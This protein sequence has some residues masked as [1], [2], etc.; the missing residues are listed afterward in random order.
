M[1]YL[2][3]FHSQE[4]TEA[5]PL[6]TQT[7]KELKNHG[8]NWHVWTYLDGEILENPSPEELEDVKASTGLL[9]GFLEEASDGCPP[10]EIAAGV[11]LAGSGRVFKPEGWRQLAE[12]LAWKP[13]LDG[14]KLAAWKSVGNYVLVLFS[15]EGLW[16]LRD[17][18]GF[19]PLFFHASSGLSMFTQTK[20]PLW[21]LGFKKIER[22]KPGWGCSLKSGGVS[23]FPLAPLQ[24]PKQA[25]VNFRDA[26]GKVSECLLEA[27]KVRVEGLKGR[28][29]V[30]FSGGLDSS[31]T[32]LMLDN[33]G[34]NPVLYTAGFEDSKD[35]ESAV[36]AA[37]TLGLPVKVR[38]LRA[39]EAEGL[40]EKSIY[41]CE[42]F[43]LLD[44]SV[45]L[46]LHAAAEEAEKEGFNIFFLGQGF[47]EL[48]AGYARYP[49]IAGEKGWKALADSLFKDVACLAEE[50][51]EREW[52]SA[53]SLGVRFELPASDLTLTLEALRLPPRFKTSSFEDPLRKKVLRRA[54]LRLG[55]PSALALKPKKAVQFSSGTVK[56]LKA[57]AGKQR[58]KVDDYLEKV[59][60]KVFRLRP[61]EA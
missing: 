26:V 40:V 2:A 37:E 33:A 29:A 31:L 10:M 12:G 44:V 19:E 8:E 55:L 23:T 51:F 53:S 30:L 17:P 49:R 52:A 32:A 16:L 34:L 36:K 25:K 35:L 41:A 4:K 43:R 3:G 38:V 42:R 58:L 6:L 9:G 60:F 46:P 20:K 22:L 11:F 48:F 56:V 1:G 47:D 24:K 39:E 50:S 57:L 13:A 5:A 54:A 27:F 18:T 15:R 14:L 61:R 7:L 45:T 21:R 59:F 28:V